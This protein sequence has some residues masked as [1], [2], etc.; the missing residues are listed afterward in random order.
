MKGFG[1]TK[2]VLFAAIVV[3]VLS[4]ILA[5]ISLFPVYTGEQQ[6]NLL[7]DNIFT[8][9][10]NETYRQGLGSFHGEEKLS[11]L[12]QSPIALAKNFS[13]VTYNGSHFNVSSNSDVAYSFIAGADYYDAVFYSESPVAGTIHFQAYVQQSKSIFPYGWLTQP[14]KIMFLVSLVAV[15]LVMLKIVFSTFSKF[16]PNKPTLPSISNKTWRYIVILIVLSI[17]IWFLI[18][19][20][21]SSPLAT[22]ENW[23]TDHARHSYVSSLFLKDGF[24]VFNQ[25]LNKLA[26][27]DNSIYKFVT[28]PEMPHLY[29]LGS[30]FLFLPFGALL[31][32]GMDPSL[33]YKIEIALFL[34]FAHICLYF[35]LK[36]FLKKDLM[37]LLKA[38]GVYIIY[39]SLVIYAADGMFDS[40]AF[41]FSLFALTMFLSERYDYFFL[42]VTV[43]IFFKYQAG[44]FLFPLILVGLIK[45]FQKNKLGSLLRNKAVILGTVLGVISVFTA[46]LSAPYLLT[47]GSHLIMNGINAFS[48]NTQIAWTLQSF[49]I[50]LTLAVTLVYAFYMLNK[51]SLL[52]LSAFFLL[53]PSFMLALLPELVFALRFCLCS[54]SSAQKR[55]R[56]NYDMVNF[57]DFCV[58]FWWGFF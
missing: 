38:V 23:Y 52:S 21:S 27:P 12:V 6:T 20:F 42:L 47:T 15:F 8:L 51:N 30:I 25:P 17:G 14:A 43:S 35:F 48:P 32:H 49:S 50:L 28:W 36:S 34:V 58:I 45:L 3:L 11:V 19:A 1:A 54:Y 46:Y 37:G 13:I 33:M 39:V 55:V 2:I 56:G 5:I 18:L 9:S 16:K 10:P 44:I 22:F 7:I 40:V 53:L 29:P 26:N 24:L 41:I 4:L 31:Q 57:Y